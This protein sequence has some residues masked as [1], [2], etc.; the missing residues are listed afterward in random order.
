MSRLSDGIVDPGTVLTFTAAGTVRLDESH[1]G[2]TLVLGKASGGQAFVLPKPV[3]GYR[4]KFVSGVDLATSNSTITTFG[5]TQNVIAGGIANPAAPAAGYTSGTE[6]DVI[7]FV[8]GAADIGDSVEMVCD[9]TNWYLTGVM[10]VS[11]AI[12]L[13]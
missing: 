6:V 12:T 1:S 5:T 8:A 2:K 9:G 7:T 10:G 11:N 4:V 13:S 3:R